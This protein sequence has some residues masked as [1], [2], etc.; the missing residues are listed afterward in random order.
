MTGGDVTLRVEV[1]GLS[2]SEVRVE[3]T[4]NEYKQMLS[5]KHRELYVVYVVTEA[6]SAKPHA[7]IFYYNSEI[8]QGSEHV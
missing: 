7:H 8:S 5:P 6:L 4:P 2:G 3:L 1:K